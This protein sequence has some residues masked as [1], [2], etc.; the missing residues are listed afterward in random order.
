MFSYDYYT[1]G[2][3]YYFE[4]VYT[5][6]GI[7]LTFDMDDLES[8]FNSKLSLRYESDGY[9]NCSLE[10]NTLEG[11]TLLNFD[12]VKAG[13]SGGGRLC[14]SI[15]LTNKETRDS[16]IEVIKKWAEIDAHEVYIRDNKIEI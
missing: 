9:G 16:L 7:N 6:P 8:M 3:D 10:Q 15:D 1:D 14:V 12:V 5:S 2:D 4:V 11:L 13:S